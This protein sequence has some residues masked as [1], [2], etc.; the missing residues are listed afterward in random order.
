MSVTTFER[1]TKE[2]Y[3]RSLANIAWAFATVRFP[4][5]VLL[6]ILA[7]SAGRRIGDVFRLLNFFRGIGPISGLTSINIE[8]SLAPFLVL[9]E[10]GP[11]SFQSFFLRFV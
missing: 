10:L 4:N 6:A 2:F 7:K 1:C 11:L 3:A 8:L 5:L 9:D